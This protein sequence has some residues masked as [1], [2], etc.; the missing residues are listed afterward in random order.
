MW[1]FQE[2]RLPLDVRFAPYSQ[3]FQELLMPTSEFARNASGI[4]ALL[5]RLED[6]IRDQANIEEARK[7]IANIGKELIGALEQFSARHRGAIVL[8][9]LPPGPN[10]PADL[11]AGLVEI[12]EDVRRHASR[13]PGVHLI[14]EEQI[15][16]VSGPDRYD[17]IS[18]QLAHIPYSES[19][20]ASIAL[21]IARRVH[22]ARVPAAKVLVLDCDN[23][24][25]HGVV[26]EDGVDGI[27]V[28][29]SFGAVQDFAVVQQE[30]G[31]LVCLASKNTETD[32]LQVFHQREDMRLQL[33][34]VVS[35]RINWTSKAANLRSLASELNLGLDTFVFVDDNP[36]E[37]AQMRSEL[38]Q[39]V[40]LQLPEEHDVPKFLKNLWILDKLNTT[41]EDLSRTQMYREN[42][43]RKALELL[44]PD[45]GQFLA[46]LDLKIDISIP[47]DDEWPR[48]EQLTQRTNQFNFT[49]RR[50]SALELKSKFANGAQI[51][52]VRVSDRFGDYGLVGVMIAERDGD[53]LLVDTFL[54]S[55]RVLGRGVE[56]EMLRRLGALGS[57]LGL[58]TVSLCYVRT[59]RNVPARAFA[60]SVVAEFCETI[61]DGVLYRIPASRAV[62]VAHRPGHDPAEVMEALASEDKKAATAAPSK[63]FARSEIYSRFADLLVSGPAIL[64]QMSTRSH[65]ARTLTSP[66]IPPSSETEVKMLRLMEEVLEM[67]QLGIDDN[68]FSLGGTSLLSVKL[69]AEIERRF[70]KQLRLTAILDAPTPRTLAALIESPSIHDRHGVITLRSGGTR[71]LF[72]VHDGLGETL[73]YLHL[74]RR[75]PETMSVYGIEPKRQPGIPLAHASIEDAAAF[76]VEQ[77]RKIQPHGPYLLGGMCAGG[78]IA[79]EMAVC[80]RGVGQSVQTI[81]VMDGATPQ[82]PKR[83]ARL[84][85]GRLLGLKSAVVRPL[86]DGSATSP[87]IMRWSSIALEVMRK[88]RNVI[89]YETG[90]LVERISMR[91]RFRLLKRLVHESGP[92]PAE[93]PPLTVMQIYNLLESHYRPTPW[94]DGHLLLVRATAGQGSDTPYRDIY[95][96]E[97]FGWRSV[98][99]QIEVVDVVGGHSSM[100]QEHAVDSLANAIIQCIGAPAAG[101]STRA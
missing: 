6:F 77:I 32:V 27:A 95:R 57:S 31:V 54:L 68:Y 90:R 94:P 28:S 59:N 56:H 83:A 86:D 47:G 7:G 16:S 49:T 52:R 100:L 76:Y 26:G 24:L 12:S 58:R 73:L 84:T 17:A 21:A 99:G 11:A 98:A 88:A 25:W 14:T 40:T 23:T 64:E 82:A 1:I 89:A 48:I 19:H 29:E 55:C 41:A 61:E 91:S 34:H 80:L 46:S 65:R 10:V 13:L 50:R 2:L 97:D 3:V 5:V 30:R 63:S 62:S 22:A 37:C 42:T 85:R 87:G 15:D 72:L 35:H 81:V 51:L 60:D 75:L 18:D 66:A 67:D 33:S 39:V 92:W 4:N 96:D 38:P 44:A 36:L 79:Y 53:A 101:A 45:I 70:G 93:V 43:A 8:A 20:L 71:N 78:T 69:F 74:A 9:V